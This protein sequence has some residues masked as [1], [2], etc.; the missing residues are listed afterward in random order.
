M[1]RI[2]RGEKIGQLETVRLAKDGRAV[3]VS[4]TISPIRDASGRV[5]GASDRRGEHPAARPC[6][7]ADLGATVLAR[8]GVTAADL[9]GVGVNPLGEPINDLF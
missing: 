4:V 1:E 2:R 7:P 6:T 9:T 3:C 5:I 8:L